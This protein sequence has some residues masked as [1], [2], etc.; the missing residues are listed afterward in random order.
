MPSKQDILSTILLF[1]AGKACD[2][3]V[4]R[5]IF[6]AMAVPEVYMGILVSTENNHRFRAL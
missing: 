6:S 5:L 1:Y 4:P 3:A 2:F